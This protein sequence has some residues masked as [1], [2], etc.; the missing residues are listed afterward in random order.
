MRT[1]W[2]EQWLDAI[3]PDEP[4]KLDRRLAWDGLSEPE[5]EQWLKSDVSADEGAEASWQQALQDCCVVL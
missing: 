3:A 1:S 5:L 2:Q 4:H